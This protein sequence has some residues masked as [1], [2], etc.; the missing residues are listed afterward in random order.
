MKSFKEFLSEIKEK[1]NTPGLSEDGAIAGC[2]VGSQGEPG[3]SPKYQP[4]LKSN[5][6]V[7]PDFPK[8]PIIQPLVTRKGPNNG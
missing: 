7:K 4:L 6:K 5:K 8:N 3:V 2:G 1:V